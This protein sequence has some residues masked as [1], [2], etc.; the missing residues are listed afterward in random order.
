MLALRVTVNGDE[1]IV[2]GSE[3]LSVLSAMITFTGKLGTKTVDPG[4]GKPDMF[5][6]LGGM[7]AR[8]ARRKDEHLRWTPHK[9]LKVGDRVL[10]ELVN[11]TKA[12]KIVD[13]S[14]AERKPPSEREYYNH[15][16]KQYL[17]LKKKYEP[18]S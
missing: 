12:N 18:E 17:A 7:T 1:P 4:R 15:I 14:P 6:H 16:K 8:D 2:G 5:V 9:Q 13:R 11:A 3:D 10:V